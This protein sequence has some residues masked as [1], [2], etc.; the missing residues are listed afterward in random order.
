VGI[1]V[2]NKI[3]NAIQ[4][5]TFNVDKQQSMVKLAKVPYLY[6]PPSW[7]PQ[8]NCTSFASSVRLLMEVESLLAGSDDE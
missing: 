8:L 7:G 5:L 6:F 4:H 1:G 3:T 2:T